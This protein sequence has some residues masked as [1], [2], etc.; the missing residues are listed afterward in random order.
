MVGHAEIMDM[1]TNYDY[2]IDYTNDADGTAET[3]GIEA[4]YGIISASQMLAWVE[5]N[6]GAACP[7]ETGRCTVLPMGRGF[8]GVR[9]RVLPQKAAPL[10]PHTPQN[11]IGTKVQ[12]LACWGREIPI[13]RAW[14]IA[15]E[16]V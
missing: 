12:H 6:C 15:G 16:G 10:H 4:G 2:T 1:L 3:W 8:A 13:G 7:G 14:A 9:G 5:T 11:K